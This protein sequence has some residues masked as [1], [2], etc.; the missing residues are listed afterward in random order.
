MSSM[1]A[2]PN[3]RKILQWKLTVLVILAP[4]AWVMTGVLG[5]P[6]VFRMMFVFYVFLGTAIFIL[7]D[8]PLPKEV[9]GPKAGIYFGIFFLAVVALVYTVGHLWPQ[10]SRA[11][12]EAGIG[13]KTKMFRDE[14]A[15]A[16]SL[17]KRAKDLSAKADEILARLN[18]LQAAGRGLDLGEFQIDNVKLSRGP[19]LSSLDPADVVGRGK[20]VYQD[21]ECY[22][23]HKI[24]GQGGKKRGPKLDNMGNL[25]TAAQLKDKIFNPKAWYADGYE[26]RKKD[27]MPDNYPDV[28]SEPELE[29]LVSYL[30]TLKDASVDTPKPVFPPGYAVK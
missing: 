6:D 27:K 4:M 13:R 11:N 3:W 24:G 5:F 1:E 23:C 25:V 28:M 18:Q 17:E 2:K 9:T 29:A 19:D 22:N 20:L 7:L 15:A 26:E 16:P 12:E 14:I 21:H 8:V 30:M 10:F